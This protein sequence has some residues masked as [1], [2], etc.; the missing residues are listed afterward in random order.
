[1]QVKAQIVEHMKG[2]WMNGCLPGGNKFSKSDQLA[3]PNT[4]RLH[5]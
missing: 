4:P 3:T 5:S 2:K 1:M